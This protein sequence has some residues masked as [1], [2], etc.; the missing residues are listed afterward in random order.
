MYKQGNSFKKQHASY[1]YIFMAEVREKEM[2]RFY[3]NKNIKEV[4]FLHYFFNFSCCSIP[5]NVTRQME[6]NFHFFSTQKAGKIEKLQQ[7]KHSFYIPIFVRLEC[8]I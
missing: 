2:C 3:A 5:S 7:D 8:K 1:G 4:P 6:M